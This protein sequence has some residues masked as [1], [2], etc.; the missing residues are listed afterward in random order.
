[1]PRGGN[2]RT[3]ALESECECT[4]CSNFL[5]WAHKQFKCNS[6]SIIEKSQSS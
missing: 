3:H 2:Y 5:D 4:V 1:V 6:K